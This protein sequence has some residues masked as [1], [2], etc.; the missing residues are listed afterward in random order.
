[1]FNL[2]VTPIVAG[3]KL[4]TAT[5]FDCPEAV[6]RNSQRNWG[7]LLQGW[8]SV[9][10]TPGQIYASGNKQNVTRVCIYIHIKNTVLNELIN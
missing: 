5:D 6:T 10:G 2:L 8:P 7:F 9:L 1:V 4:T 3:V